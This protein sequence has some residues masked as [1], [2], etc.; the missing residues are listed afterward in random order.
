MFSG[1]FGV[2]TIGKFSGVG[3]A[4]S[5]SGALGG[6]GGAASAGM[7][8]NPVGLA[9]AGGQMALSIANMFQQD[10]AATQQAYD[11]SYQNTL[12]QFK[13]QQQN[14]QIAAA[15]TAKID[16]VKN[17][18]EN[19]FLAAQASYTAEQYRL[20]DI[21]GQAAFKQSDMV[22]RMAE[23]MGSSAAREVYG[24][25]AA[26]GAAVG[27]MGAYGRSSRQL[28]EQLISETGQSERN[29]SKI[30]QQVVGANKQAV[31]Q[32]AV[33]PQMQFATPMNQQFGQGALGSA[34]QIGTAAMGA[35]QT[36]WGVT[37]GG[38]SFL[39]ITKPKG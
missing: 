3:K 7:L 37:P 14:K 23:A 33:I 35:F 30:E 6:A 2:D 25:S 11:Q 21:Y 26:R 8:A 39:G 29:M 17:Q 19:N 1:G 9:L 27:V 15:Y 36:G 32:L 31:S 16:Y 5:G 38:G 20:N 12:N 4:L 22:K 13:V 10:Q 34:L 28:V 24:K 18:I